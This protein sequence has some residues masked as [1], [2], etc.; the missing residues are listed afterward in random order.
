MRNTQRNRLA[1][2][3]LVLTLV[4]GGLGVAYLAPTLKIAQAQSSQE[5]LAG[6]PSTITVVGEGTVQIQPDIAV[7]TI[8]VQ[9]ADA[10]VQTASSNAQTTMEAV[11]AAIQEQGVASEDIQTTGFTIFAEFAPVDPASQQTQEP[12]YRVSNNVNV[13][14]RSLEQVATVLDAAIAAGANNIFGVT[15]SLDDSSQAEA[16]AR[17]QAI[18]QAAAKAAEI[19]GLTNLQLGSVLSVSEVI[20]S[21]GGYFASPGLR[22][23]AAGMG[24]GSPISPGQLNVTIQ[25]EVVYSAAQAE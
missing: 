17:S 5:G 16:D 25:L 21:Q 4:C 12:L 23:D 15:F 11:L 8:G 13:T 20:G 10:E 7:A 2:V 9:V 22:T 1:L 3:C 24:G 19:A 14:I 18:E 6:L